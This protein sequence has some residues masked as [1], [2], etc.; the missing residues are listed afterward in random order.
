[1]TRT[2]GAAAIVG[3]GS[4]ALTMCGSFQLESVCVRAASRSAPV[5]V[6]TGDQW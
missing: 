2:A 4:L 5:S 1:M 3:V 6:V